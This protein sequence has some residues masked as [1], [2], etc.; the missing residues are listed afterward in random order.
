[1]SSELLYKSNRP[2]VSM[3]YRHEKPLGNA[4]RTLKEFVNHLPV[5]RD[6]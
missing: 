2:H 4:G 5:A 6:L 1:M 3:V